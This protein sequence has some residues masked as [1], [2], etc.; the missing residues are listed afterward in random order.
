MK[1]AVPC[2]VALA[3]LAHTTASSFTEPAPRLADLVHDY[4]REATPYSP[5]LASESGLHQY[6]RV[7]ANTIGEEYRTGLGDI[8]SRHLAGVRRI[9][10]ATLGEQDRVTR[11]VFE[12]NL[13]RCVERLRLPWHLL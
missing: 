3:V 12:F 4:Q 13:D 6:D 2:A 5:F 1:R 11:D 10:A 7:L 9:D 8:C